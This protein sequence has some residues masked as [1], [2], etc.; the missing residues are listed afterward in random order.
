MYH[1]YMIYYMIYINMIYI[2]MMYI[3]YHILHTY[4]LHTTY[5]TLHIKYDV[6]HTCLPLARLEDGDTVLNSLIHLVIGYARNPCRFVLE[7]IVLYMIHNIS[8]VTCYLLHIKY[9]LFAILYSSI[10]IFHHTLYIIHI[11]HYIHVHIHTHHSW[12]FRCASQTPQCLQYP[13][14]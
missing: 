12:C 8:H 10:S 5:Y 9:Y 14:Y 7:C 2:N 13:T 1:I 4:I 6:V 3:M 11:T